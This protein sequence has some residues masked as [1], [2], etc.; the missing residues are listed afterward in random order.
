MDEQTFV[1]VE[2]GGRRLFG[3]GKAQSYTY[4][5]RGVIPVVRVGRRLLVPVAALERLTEEL[6]EEAAVTA[7]ANWRGARAASSD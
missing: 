5:Q 7:A 1:S 2:E 4:V 3:V 6:A